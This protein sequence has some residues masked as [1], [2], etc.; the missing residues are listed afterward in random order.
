MTVGTICPFHGPCS[1]TEAWTPRC[2]QRSTE[3]LLPLDL[4]DQRSSQCP[5]TPVRPAALGISHPFFPETLFT[6]SLEPQ[7]IRSHHMPCASY[8][9]FVS[10]QC[11]LPAGPVL[12]LSCCPGAGDLRGWVNTVPPLWLGPGCTA[13]LLLPHGTLYYSGVLSLLRD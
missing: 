9:T 8:Y 7:T 4:L 1:P 11:K 12:P 3:H 6:P 10:I 5:G 13:G 2:S